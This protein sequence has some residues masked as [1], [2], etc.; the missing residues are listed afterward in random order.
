M[1]LANLQ[2]MKQ[3]LEDDWYLFQDDDVEE[4]RISAEIGKVNGMIEEQITL[5]I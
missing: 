3:S 2:E 5:A 1:T 4:E